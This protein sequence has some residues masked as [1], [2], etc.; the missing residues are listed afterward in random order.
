L[1][2]A[3]AQI[4]ALLAAV[5]VEEHFLEVDTLFL[6]VLVTQLRLVAEEPVLLGVVRPTDQ[7]LLRLVKR[8]VVE[9]E[10]VLASMQLALEAVAAVVVV[11]LR[12]PVEAELRVKAVLVGTPEL[13]LWLR[14]AE[15][16]LGQPM[17]GLV[18]TLHPGQPIISQTY[19]VAPEVMVEQQLCEAQLSILVVAAAAEHF[20]AVILFVLPGLEGLE[21]AET[22]VEMVSIGVYASV[23]G[24][25]LV[26]FIS[27]KMVAQ[28]LAVER[29]VVKGVSVARN[30]QMA[31]QV[32]LF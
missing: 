4:D 7:I 26:L 23:V 18:L 21:A 10:A 22:V 16:V 12:V 1:Q 9:E 13:V 20:T 27:L 31:G 5:V 28:I 30:S 25:A 6:R 15:V 11:N 29:A 2:G 32:L 8:Q 24:L 3:V 19:K 14:L 17:E